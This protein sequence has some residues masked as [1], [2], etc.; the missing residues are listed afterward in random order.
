MV[1]TLQST[2]T[3][4]SCADK[5]E[6]RAIKFEPDLPDPPGEDER[7][8]SVD[9]VKNGN[10]ETWPPK[11][12]GKALEMIKYEYVEMVKITERHHWLTVFTTEILPIINKEPFHMKSTVLAVIYHNLDKRKCG[13]CTNSKECFDTRYCKGGVEDEAYIM[14]PYDKLPQEVFDE[15]DPVLER[16]YER[17]GKWP[18]EDVFLESTVHS[19]LEAQKKTGIDAYHKMMLMAI[20]KK[21]DDCM[22]F[23]GGWNVYGA[24]KN[25]I[26]NSLESGVQYLFGEEMI[27]EER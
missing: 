3:E 14:I 25:G 8:T 21:P 9:F 22:M 6:R 10:L 7:V 2:D 4:E 15:F 24:P 23:C 12:K 26:I 1:R 20:Q 16:M 13:R 17:T 27:D 18:S 5:L 19:E 11:V